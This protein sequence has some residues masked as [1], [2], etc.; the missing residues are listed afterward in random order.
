[1]LLLGLEAESTQC[2]FWRWGVPGCA[3]QTSPLPRTTNSV[4]HISS[5]QTAGLIYNLLTSIIFRICQSVACLTNFSTFRSTTSSHTINAAH[6]CL[7]A[8]CMTGL[9]VL[10]TCPT[11]DRAFTWTECQTL[12]GLASTVE[13]AERLSV[14]FVSRLAKTVPCVG[15]AEKSQDGRKC[16]ALPRLT[17]DNRGVLKKKASES[18]SLILTCTKAACGSN[19]CAG[20][21]NRMPADG[22]GCGCPELLLMQTHFATVRANP[23]LLEWRRADSRRCVLCCKR[24]VR[25]QA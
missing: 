4:C 21:A 25:K 24:D 22:S 1:M 12:V 5:S 13:I 16:R 3:D 9:P 8:C 6:R 15:P 23:P 14:A 10:P 2:N 17:R 19:V 18:S 7:P 20:C 11:C